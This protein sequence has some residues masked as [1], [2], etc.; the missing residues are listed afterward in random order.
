MFGIKK[1]NRTL[2]RFAFVENP[3][4][5]KNLHIKREKQSKK[6]NIQEKLAKVLNMMSPQPSNLQV[7]TG[8][9]NTFDKHKHRFKH[10][11]L[12][13]FFFLKKFIPYLA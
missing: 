4:F 1:E 7:K 5:P 6:G 12:A 9:K 10:D 3:L 13:P 11:A 2:K 8:R